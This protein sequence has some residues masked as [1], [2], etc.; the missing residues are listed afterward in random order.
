[1]TIRSHGSG[2]VN[3]VLAREGRQSVGPAIPVVPCSRELTRYHHSIWHDILV[4][5]VPVVEKI[6]HTIFVYAPIVLLFR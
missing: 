1:M 3:G 6:L 5:Q 4:V 2:D